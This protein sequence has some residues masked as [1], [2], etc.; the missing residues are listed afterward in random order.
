MEKEDLRREIAERARVEEELRRSRDQLQVI[1]HGVADGITVQ[2]RT[3]KLVYANR[4]AVRVMGFETPEELLSTPI[5]EV[6]ERFEVL[7]E[8]RN[9]LPLSSLPGR[10][11][12]Q[13]QE[14]PDRVVCWRV[15]ATGEEHWSIVKARPV[16]DDHGQVQMVINVFE[17]ITEQK[18][19]EEEVRRLNRSLEAANR[20]LQAFAFTAS[21]DLQA[22]LRAIAGYADALMEDYSGQLDEEGRAYLERIRTNARRMSELVNNLLSLARVDRDPLDQVEIDM[23]ALARSVFYELRE[24]YRD[25]KVDL[26]VLDMPPARVRRST[27]RCR[28]D[29]Y[30]PHD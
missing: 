9:P 14:A 7:N 20:D 15:K 13:G 12:L 1:L 25:R 29:C 26:R 3:G 21:H 8:Q 2:D 6:M 27:S 17:D 11:A 18:R 10:L 19:S 4:A 22:P 30:S 28:Y 24:L 5:A 23:G 16:F